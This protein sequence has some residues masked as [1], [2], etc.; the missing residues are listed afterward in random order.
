MARMPELGHFPT[1]EEVENMRATL[2]KWLSSSQIE[3][4]GC[5]E[6]PPDAEAEEMFNRPGYGTIWI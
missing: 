2:E 4:Q 5:P 6:G 3:Q 1:A